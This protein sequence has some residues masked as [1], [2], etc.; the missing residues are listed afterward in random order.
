M[1]EEEIAV[2]APTEV[3]NEEITS[4][5]TTD[6]KRKLDQADDD[7][8]TTLPVDDLPNEESD[9]KKPRVEKEFDEPALTNGHE[10]K[11]PEVENTETVMSGNAET[12]IS[13]NA[14][15][16]NVQNVKELENTC[17]GSAL[18]VEADN[19]EH[20]AVD[21]TLVEKG[22]NQTAEVTC[23]ADVRESS[24][25]VLK[26]GDIQDPSGDLLHP[27]PEI[28]STMR[29]I[30]VPNNKVGVL[31]GKSGDTIRFLQLNSGAKI[32]ILRDTEADP[33]APSRPVELTGSL[34]SINKAETLIKDVIAVADGGGSPS[35]VAK[36]FG[37]VQ[38]SG[39][40]D[41]IQFQVPN[42]K[43]GL[44]IGK[45][46]ET[47]KNLQ[48]RSRTRIQLIPQHLP[49]GDQ[50][51][52]RTVRV[53]GDKKQIEVARNMIT[54]VMSQIARSSPLSGGSN[55]RGQ[56]RGQWGPHG[57][58]A[59]ARGYD[60]QQQGV[61]PSQ[62]P[63]YMPPPYGGYPQQQ[64]DPRSNFNGPPRGGYAHGPDYGHPQSTPSHQNY[65]HTNQGNSQPYPQEVASHS[66]YAQ[67]PYS[68]PPAYG[69]PSQGPPQS[70]APYQNP[71]QHYPYTSGGP[72]QQPSSYPYNS[73]PPANDVYSQPPAH[74]TPAPVYGQPGG[75]QV[76]PVYGQPGGQAAQSYGQPGGQMTQS[77]GQPGG[78]VAAPG[79]GVQAAPGY[80][81]P[82]G[83]ATAPVYSQPG[84]QP[85]PIYGQPGGQVAAPGYVQ[86]GG[87][88]APAG[89]G[90]YPGYGEQQ[91][92][93]SNAVAYG[94][95]QQ[96]GTSEASYATAA[97]VSAYTA[98]PTSNQAAMYEQPTPQ[99]ASAP[100]YATQQVYG[101]QH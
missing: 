34:E 5:N 46:G 72:A 41:H 79:Y 19:V 26:T 6:L 17:T 98:P 15:V 66:G 55:Q 85:A 52:E 47:I 9:A 33:Y 7:N 60:K 62:N 70:Y 92:P 59:Q 76:A 39:A 1:A 31:I 68:M 24:D 80:G 18:D 20:V 93:A 40:A 61:Y 42:E 82:G 81:Q 58:T 83:Q 100:V 77:Y 27:V 69:M 63:Q 3:I 74:S 25:E 14:E 35:L 12:V 44:I 4:P 73:A 51:K 29:R 95:Y 43:V 101:G 30:E 48:T 21:N 23:V 32:Q 16:E 97:P 13:V 65:G 78:Q 99:Y 38:G 49:E 45:G 8:K 90:S 22:D 84:S 50:S 64:A 96:Q 28:Q 89:Y 56:P 37:T 53:T 36:G 2:A 94:G 75:G 87:Q 86:P 71:S 67:Q 10:M 91:Q 88:V 57:S 54:E 11:E